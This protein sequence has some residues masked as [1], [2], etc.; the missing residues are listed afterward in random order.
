MKTKMNKIYV[1]IERARLSCSHSSVSPHCRSE[2]KSK[3][4]AVFF[5]I[6]KAKRVISE[7]FILNQRKNRL[8]ED[9]AVFYEFI[10]FL[11]FPSS[12]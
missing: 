9:R 6:G 7:Y 4:A 11:N 1:R 3:D 12:A 8:M 5:P 2:A 10:I